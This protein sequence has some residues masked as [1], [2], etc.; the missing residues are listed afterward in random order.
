MAYNS[1]ILKP[2]VGYFHK[3]TLIK[4]LDTNFVSD[5]EYD[6]IWGTFYPA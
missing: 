4:G 3:S 1:F 6:G 2:K 5:L